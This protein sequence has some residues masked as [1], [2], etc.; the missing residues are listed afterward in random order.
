MF[1][2]IYDRWPGLETYD[3]CQ[4]PADPDGTQGPEPLPVTQIELTRAESEAIDWD[5][6]TVEDLVRGSLAD[7]PQLALRV[8]PELAADPAYQAIV[9]DDDRRRRQRLAR[10]PTPHPAGARPR[11]SA[12]RSP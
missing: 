9:G 1:S 3:V 8:S 2:D 12:G 5:S 10:L 11:R 4:E 6:V 7:P